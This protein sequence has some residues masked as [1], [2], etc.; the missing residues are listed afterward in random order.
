MQAE[1]RD[2]WDKN[3]TKQTEITN[4]GKYSQAHN[5]SFVSTQQNCF[6]ILTLNFE[7]KNNACK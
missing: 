1:S 5:F 7:K 4:K 6:S 2:L 3:H